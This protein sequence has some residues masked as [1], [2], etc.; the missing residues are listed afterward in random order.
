MRSGRTNVISLWMPVDRPTI[1]FLRVLNAVS[2][3]VRESGYDLMVVGLDSS[4]A[5]GSEA[6]VP[7]QWPADGL[8][9]F[10]AG[11]AIGEFRKCPANTSIPLV[12]IGLEQ[13]EHADTVGWDVR[14]A[15]HEVT[16]RLVNSGCR[17]IVHV[18]PQ[19]VLDG[20]PLE[21]RR[22]GYSEAMTEC[23]LEAVFLGV[24]DETASATEQAVNRALDGQPAP[25]AFFCFTDQI[26]VGTLRA[27]RTSGV[28]VPDPCQVWG[29]GNYP[30]AADHSTPVSTI[31]IPHTALVDQAWKWLLERIDKPKRPARFV[32]I[33]IPI[34]ERAST[35]K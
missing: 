12:V 35:L 27:L 20:F 30:E 16:L 23:G 10:D 33:P 17:R 25:E 5:Y 14:G 31:E 26:A 29:Y 7:Q 11:R 15:A 8:I 32:N 9:S 3:K 18:T 1:T 34:I 22:R 21:Q 24:A 13:F 28:S 6:R 19:W 2:H 4:V